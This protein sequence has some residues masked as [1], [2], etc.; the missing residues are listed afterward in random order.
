MYDQESHRISGRIVSIDQPRV[1]PIV[2]GKA[3]RPVEF[4]A[5]FTV[6][7]VDGYV[8]LERLSWENYHEANDLIDHI[9]RH[10]ERFGYYPES[11]H[12]PEQSCHR[13]A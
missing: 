7:V 11:V 13:S 12:I 9:E 10:R 2:R 5:K 3:G 4:G 6:S 1:R 8:F